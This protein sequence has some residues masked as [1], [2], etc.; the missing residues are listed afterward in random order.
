M[1]RYEDLDSLSAPALPSLSTLLSAANS[2]HTSLSALLQPFGPGLHQQLPSLVTVGLESAGRT[3]IQYGA[4]GVAQSGVLASPVDLQVSGAADRVLEEAFC[5]AAP[6]DNPAEDNGPLENYRLQQSLQRSTA[7]TAAAS[8]YQTN[9]SSSRA[10]GIAG[11][12][13]AVQS[14]PAV[15]FTSSASGTASIAG[16]GSTAAARGSTA[17]SISAK[18]L[19]QLELVACQHNTVVSEGSMRDMLSA[20]EALARTRRRRLLR[21]LRNTREARDSLVTALQTSTPAQVLSALNSSFAGLSSLDNVHVEVCDDQ[22]CVLVD[23][24]DSNGSSSSP[25]PPLGAVDAQS[26][27]AG[28]FENSITALDIS[29]PGAEL[30]SWSLAGSDPLECDRKC[31]DCVRFAHPMCASV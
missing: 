21:L 29:G 10:G 17:R 4:A 5:L 30:V 26:A 15:R 27:A 3:D 8:E 1:E 24:W 25:A 9:S 22:G 20:S 23:L 16:T 13:T 12:R 7:R 31:M 6:P 11:S 2:E 28:A 19:D 18:S 14:A